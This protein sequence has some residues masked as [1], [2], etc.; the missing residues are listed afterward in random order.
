MQAKQNNQAS[1]VFL[2]WGGLIKIL[3]NFKSNLE[4]FKSK[5]YTHTLTGIESTTFFLRSSVWND[6]SA[7]K[8]CQVMKQLSLFNGNL[9]TKHFQFRDKLFSNFE[10]LFFFSPIWRRT[11]FE[12]QI[13]LRC[14]KFSNQSGTVLNL[15][16][17]VG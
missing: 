6:H 3:F 14:D 4:K 1:K 8:K 10:Q 16:F 11:N 7:Q 9:A 17:F 5:L 15:L 2:E 13:L 12:F